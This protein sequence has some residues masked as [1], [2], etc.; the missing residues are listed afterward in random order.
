M[1]EWMYTLGMDANLER[2][3]RSRAN[4]DLALLSQGLHD[5]LRLQDID[6]V[7]T[8][9]GFRPLTEGI[10]CGREGR[11]HEQVGDRTHLLLTWYKYDTGRYEVVVY[12]S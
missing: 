6:N 1:P 4:S 2:R 3:N 11:V 8:T 12:L 10:Y 7:L 5:S 9:H